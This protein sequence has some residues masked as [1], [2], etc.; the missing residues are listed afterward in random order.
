[1]C[2]NSH[3]K[4]ITVPR[5]MHWWSMRH[6]KRPRQPWKD[7]TVRT[8]WAS[9]SAL[10]GDLSEVPPRTRGGE[11][12]MIIYVYLAVVAEYCNVNFGR[13]KLFDRKKQ[14]TNCQLWW[15]CQCSYKICDLN[16]L[17]NVHTYCRT[18]HLMYFNFNDWGIFL[19]NWRV[20]SQDWWTETQQKSRQEAALS[21]AVVIG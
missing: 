1:M 10:T 5:D 12:G 15:C 14:N 2:N 21:L 20:F 17:C 6:T 13:M 9:L 7:S 18:T 3:N 16:Y 19:F 8:W 4:L 11:G